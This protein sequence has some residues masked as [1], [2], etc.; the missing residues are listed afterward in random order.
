MIDQTRLARIA[1]GCVAEP[2]SKD[3]FQAVRAHGPVEALGRIIRGADS[4]GEGVLARLGNGDPWE[5]AT[6]R[7]EHAD[8]TG[9]RIVTPEDPEWPPQL[10]DLRSISREGGDRI[11]R[12]TFPPQCLWVRGPL[13]L[14][15]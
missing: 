15:E 14:L 10:D 5:L 1:L 7:L 12:D 4:L 8:R 9:M 11:A 2:G 6:R 13:P 3:L